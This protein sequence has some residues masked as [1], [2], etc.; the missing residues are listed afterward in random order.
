MDDFDKD[1]VLQWYGW[2]EDELLDIFKYIPPTEQNLETFSPRLASLIIESCGLLDSVLRQVSG[3]VSIVDG[4][5]VHRHD[6]DIRDYARLYADRYQIPSAKSILLI[7]P[8][9]YISP[10]EEWTTLITGGDYKPVGWWRTHTELKH[11]RIANLKNARLKCA[12]ES[13]CG[14]H[15]IVSTLPEFGR[16]VLARGW[17]PGKKTSPQTTIEILEG[18]GSGSL[19]V[20]SKLFVIS[21]GNEKFPQRIED[22]HPSLFNASERVTDF[23]GRF[24]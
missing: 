7:T 23:F 6:L 16:T 20:E 1:Q 5:R 17:I 9:R 12:I 14:L 13:L 19:L 21:R 10:F 3:E 15:L 11:D 18:F 4:K 8:P 24:Y 22:F 2:L